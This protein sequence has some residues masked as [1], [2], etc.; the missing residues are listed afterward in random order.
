M[1]EVAVDS[2]GTTIFNHMPHRLAAR[3][4]PFHGEG[5]GSNWLVAFGPIA[6]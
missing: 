2:A 5:T 1:A 4:P 6:S 3:T